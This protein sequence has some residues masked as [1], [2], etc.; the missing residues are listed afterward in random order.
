[1][2]WSRPECITLS[3]VTS[4]VSSVP[5]AASAQDK[6]PNLFGGE[7]FLGYKKQQICKIF[8]LSY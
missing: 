4:A 5:S 3:A 1:M 6:Q 7:A 8:M 2:E